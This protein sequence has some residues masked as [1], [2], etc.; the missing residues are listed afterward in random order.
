MAVSYSEPPDGLE[1]FATAV[2]SRD[3]SRSAG[4][5]NESRPERLY[6]SYD[7]DERSIFVDASTAQT[8]LAETDGGVKSTGGEQA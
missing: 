1:E 5:K 7:P 2:A 8:T 3:Y 6:L 4:F